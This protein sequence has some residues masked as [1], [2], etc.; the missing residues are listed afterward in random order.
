LIAIAAWVLAGAWGHRGLP[1]ANRDLRAKFPL[2]CLGWKWRKR[3][4]R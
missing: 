2:S 1:A 3:S 4:S